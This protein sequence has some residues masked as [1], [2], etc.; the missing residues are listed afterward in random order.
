MPLLWTQCY[1]LFINGRGDAWI[2][3]TW[4]YVEAKHKYGTLKIRR[5][6]A[7]S[8]RSIYGTYTAL[9]RIKFYEETPVNTFLSGYVDTIEQKHFVWRELNLFDDSPIDVSLHPLHHGNIYTRSRTLEQ[10]YNHCKNTK[11]L[12]RSFLY[13]GFIAS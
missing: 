4:V 13:K 10:M 7:P 1:I 12:N 11:Y 8:Y 6:H 9:F 3:A 2:L 5:L